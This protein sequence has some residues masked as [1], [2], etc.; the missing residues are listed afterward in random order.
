MTALATI[1]AAV[2]VLLLTP[3]PGGRP[4]RDPAPG[5][6]SGDVGVESPSG[7]GV[8]R[9]WRALWALLAA[10][11]AGVLVGG[12]LTLPAGLAGGA[13]VWVVAGRLEPVDVRLRREEVRRDL[14]H[15]VTLLAAALR[16]GVGPSA[17]LDL[18]C[19]ALPGAAAERLVPVAARAGDVVVSEARFC[20]EG[21]EDDG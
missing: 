16:S 9:R 12:P 17:A 19:R 2:A 14:P 3:R 15:V 20:A 10:A 5:D 21:W 7:D 11:G 1:C 4:V 6:V 18:V 13:A 8:L